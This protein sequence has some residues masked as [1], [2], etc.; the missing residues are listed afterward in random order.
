MLHPIVSQNSHA[1]A[2]VVTRSRLGLDAHLREVEGGRCMLK[3]ITISK[4]MR[5]NLH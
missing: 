2:S 1:Y 5:A 4:R 3:R